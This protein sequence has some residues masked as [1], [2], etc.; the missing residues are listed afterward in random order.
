MDI[1]NM[2]LSRISKL[3]LDRDQMTANEALTRRRNYKVTLVCGPDVARSYTL[4]LAVMTAATIA[5]RCFPGAVK[6]AVD[7][8]IVDS[9]LLVWPM[10]G[11]TFGESL[12]HLVGAAALVEPQTLVEN[13]L[14]I[15]FGNATAT[16]GALRVTFD[17]WVAKT[18][19]AADVERLPE[20]QY[21]SL[22]GVLAATLAVAEAFF[23]FAEIC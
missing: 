19:P 6:I 2:E 5:N 23:S 4:Q 18:G 17:G 14:A 3:F 8:Q 15:V 11:F 9:P 12:A 7:R 13:N 16:K 10:C 22:A 20:R 21:C 1:G